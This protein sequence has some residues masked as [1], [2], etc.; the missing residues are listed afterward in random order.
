MPRGAGGTEIT[1]MH[2]F[3]GV[4]GFALLVTILWD[5]F[6]SVILPRH[7]RRDFRFARFFFRTAW[8]IW[9]GTAE[10]IRTVKRRESYLSYF[11]PLSL[12]QLIAC[13]ALALVLAFAMLQW[14]A[15]S[16]LN[17]TGNSTGFDSDLYFSGTTFFTLG[18]GDITP[19]SSG[20]RVLSVIE[21]G[22]VFVFLRLYIS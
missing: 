1:T 21:A 3:I 11:G 9:S 10:H 7:V 15:G 17:S 8:A 6:E 2:A 18:L 16:A 14:A 13:W 20:A 4:L 5:S 12:L 22:K 19:R